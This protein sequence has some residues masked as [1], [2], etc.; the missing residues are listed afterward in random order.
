MT[1]TDRDRRALILLGVAGSLILIY[2]FATS[3]SSAPAPI[4]PATT[5]PLAERRLAKVREIAASVP[6]KE[7]VLANVHKELVDREKGLIQADTAAQAQAQLLAVLRR[8]GQAQ[9]P[10]IGQ[11]RQVEIGQVRPLGEEYGEVQV[12]VSFDCRIEQLINMLSDLTSQNELIATSE[13]RIGAATP[14]EK[15]LPVRMTASGAVRK[16]LIPEKKGTSPL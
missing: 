8:V 5:V 7:E 2:W 1:I 6:G 3:D 16:Q 12:T 15:M 4:A 10:P 11:F 13:L 14:K 9:K